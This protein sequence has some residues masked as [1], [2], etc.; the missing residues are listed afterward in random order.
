[1]YGAVFDLGLRN[2]V[3]NVSYFEIHAFHCEERRQVGGVGRHQNEREE[4]PCTLRAPPRERPA[5]ILIFI[6]KKTPSKT[7]H[8]TA[9]I[10]SF[11]M[12]FDIFSYKIKFPK[13]NLGDMSDPCCIRA[14]SVLHRELDM[15]NSL[16]GPSSEFW[17]HSNGLNRPIR[18]RITL[19]VR[20]PIAIHNQTFL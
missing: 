19:V 12:Q 13:N 6:V 16:D 14:P 8:K 10:C 9:I 15:L 11:N 3:I 7:Q 2:K 4:P 5:S 18:N 17:D 1:M 20:K